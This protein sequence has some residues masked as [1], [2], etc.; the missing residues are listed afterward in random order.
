MSITINWPASNTGVATAVRIYASTTRMADDALG[1]P[2]ATLAGT[3]TSY[4]W[5]P[6]T[7]N[8]VYYFRIAI[9]RDTFT[10]LG[11]NQP[12]GYFSTTGPGVQDIIRGNWELGYF[13]R[14]PVASMLSASALRTAV[15]AGAIGTAVPDANITYYYKFVRN[16]KILFYPAG[17]IITTVTWDQL[18]N[19]GLVYGT[20]D[21]GAYPAGAALTPTNQKKLVTIGGFSFLARCP[22]GS[23]LPTT[24][25]V[26]TATADK[27]N[28][29]WD[30][31]MGRVHTNATLSW[32]IGALLDDNSTVPTS[33]QGAFTQHLLVATGTP[34]AALHRGSGTIDAINQVST[35]S[36]TYGWAPFLELQF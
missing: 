22:K 26:T 32:N 7:D 11:D 3:A 36:A 17:A 16:G 10:F 8:T 33:T 4:V 1:D 6:P 13:G 12:Y 18:Y 14:V 2:I 31:T 15:G 34:K 19:L 30:Q 35:S 5:N 9:D 28:S 24:T 25:L 23:T 27:E 29:E 20:D 21:N